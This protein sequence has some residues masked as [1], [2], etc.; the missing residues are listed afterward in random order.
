MSC[1]QRDKG[2]PV[3][4]FLVHITHPS[5]Y[6]IILLQISLLN[7]SC[8]LSP[9]WQD[10]SGNISNGRCRATL[11]LKRIIATFFFQLYILNVSLWHAEIIWSQSAC[12]CETL[13]SGVKHL[14]IIIYQ[15]TQALAHVLMTD[16]CWKLTDQCMNSLSIMIRGQWGTLGHT[17]A[18]L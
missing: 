2:Q 16:L 6:M 7:I 18:C 5:C 13:L 10:S 12:T 14:A 4:P 15:D 1:W 3:I 17:A 8:I 11:D 9:V